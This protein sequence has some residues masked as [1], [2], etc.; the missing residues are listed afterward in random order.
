MKRIYFLAISFLLFSSAC[1]SPNKKQHENKLQKAN[2]FQNNSAEATA[3]PENM[4]G[5]GNLTDSTH[6]DTGVRRSN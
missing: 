1:N 5:S 4:I 2:T 6:T 3:K